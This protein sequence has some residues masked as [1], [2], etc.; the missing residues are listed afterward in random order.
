MEKQSSFNTGG[1]LKGVSPTITITHAPNKQP[2]GTGQSKGKKGMNETELEEDLA[3][4]TAKSSTSAAQPKGKKS[5][6]E[7]EAELAE[8][9]AK[10]E[11]RKMELDKLKK[12]ASDNNRKIKLSTLE[13][14]VQNAKRYDSWAKEE[15]SQLKPDREKIEN[16]LHLAREAEKEANA[17]RLDLGIAQ[18]ESV[19]VAP[20]VSKSFWEANHGAAWVVSLCLAIISIWTCYH[21]V[22]T[23][24]AEIDIANSTIV[25]PSLKIGNPY[26]ESS[27]QG[28]IYDN[29]V[30]FTDIPKLWLFLL[31][32][33]PPIFFYCL[34][35]V[36]TKV[37]PWLDWQ[38]VSPAT[39]LW[40]LY[41]FSASIFLVSALYH[42]AGNGR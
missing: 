5:L 14:C 35:F 6:T 1:I 26:D 18:A 9:M 24:K 32:L 13:E 41:A 40:L 38:E 15:G 25:D 7:L 28:I 42:L 22:M 39:R 29:L 23:Y 37:S 30:Q 34:P 27:I 10:T 17:L 31:I 2:S 19:E 4:S 20:E 11:A 21:F 36:K 12:E 8:E 33:V 3:I 16:Y